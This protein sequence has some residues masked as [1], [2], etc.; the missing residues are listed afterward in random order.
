[1]N[2]QGAITHGVSALMLAAALIGGAQYY[3]SH[4]DLLTPWKG[5]GYGMYTEP[6]PNY[7]SVWAL[8][9]GGEG[10]AAVR[11]FPRPAGDLAALAGGVIPRDRQIAILRQAAY[12]RFFPRAAEAARLQALIGA[13]TRIEV[14]ELRLSVAHGEIRTRRLFVAEPAR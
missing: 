5:G 4:F 7:R 6:H 3:Q 13:P 14:H 8:G 10:A 1:M 2:R 9:A 11:L 12:L